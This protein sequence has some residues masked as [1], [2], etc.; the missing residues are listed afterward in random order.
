[1]ISG[2]L[3]EENVETSKLDGCETEQ[4]LGQGEVL[5][6]TGLAV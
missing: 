2:K 3:A 5:K 4:R 1:M 6:V